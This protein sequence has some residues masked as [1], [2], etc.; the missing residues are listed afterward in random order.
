MCN[1]KMKTN[2]KTIV[3][4]IHIANVSHI[5]SAISVAD[6]ILFLQKK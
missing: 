2:K 6:I 1:G 3:E 5:G 4:M